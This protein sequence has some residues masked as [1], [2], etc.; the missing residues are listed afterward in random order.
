MKRNSR[1]TASGVANGALDEGENNKHKSNGDSVAVAQPA[2]ADLSVILAGCKP[3][4]MEIFRYA[5][6]APGR[7]SL[8]RLQIPLIPSSPPINRWRKN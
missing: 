4:G 3:C 8:A 7:D 5:F 2:P 1:D 6:P